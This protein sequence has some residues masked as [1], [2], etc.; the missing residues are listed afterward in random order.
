[1]AYQLEEL[2]KKCEMCGKTWYFTSRDMLDSASNRFAKKA[3]SFGA[4]TQA[5]GGSF[6]GAS[7]MNAQADRAAA[8]IVDYDQCP[9]CGSRK[10]RWLTKEERERRFK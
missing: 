8:Q 2:G 3:N 1:M 4:F 6:L 5:I 10:S 9:N 7:I